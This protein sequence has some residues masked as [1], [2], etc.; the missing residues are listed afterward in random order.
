[1]RPKP[2]VMHLTGWT[3]FPS[4]GDSMDIPENWHY[5]AHP[6]YNQISQDWIIGVKWSAKGHIKVGVMSSRIGSLI[7][8]IAVLWS[9]VGSAETHVVQ[10]E[11]PVPFH[12]FILLDLGA[13][14]SGISRVDIRAVGIGGQGYYTCRGPEQSGWFDMD[15]QIRLGNHWFVASA[16]YLKAFD[17]TG[18]AVVPEGDPGGC[19]N[20]PNCPLMVT[21]WP[22][23]VDSDWCMLEDAF[24]PEVSLKEITITCDTLVSSGQKTWGA[25][26]AIYYQEARD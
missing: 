26:K 19:E 24:L 3:K 23:G 7:F 12:T 25:I 20:T 11:G 15:I 6:L 16:D 22:Q 21:D 8:L 4:A 5:S 17:V 10:I 14:V 1:M 9:L 13:E 2:A 18:E